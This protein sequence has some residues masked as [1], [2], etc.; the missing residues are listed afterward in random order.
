SLSSCNKFLDEVPDN[1]V[2]PQ[3]PDQLLMMMVDGYSFGNY[4]KYCELSSD[5]I[6]D[7]NSP[8]KEGVRYNLTSASV[9][10]D[11]MFAWEDA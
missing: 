10:D 11:E 6:V 3:T 1:R 4:A 7:N 8:D 2:D 9:I 5:N